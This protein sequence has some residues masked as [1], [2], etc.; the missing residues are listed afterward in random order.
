V[1]APWLAERLRL[2]VEQARQALLDHVR[3]CLDTCHLA[4]AFEDPV[5][6]LERYTGLGIQ[7][8]KLQIS[9]GPRVLLPEDRTARAALVA[10]L[11]PFADSPYLHQVGQRNR[12][13]SLQSYPDLVDALERIHDPEIAEWRI[14]FHAPIFIERY[15]SF[16]ST[17][18][19][20]RRTLE[21]VRQRGCCD[22]FEIETYTWDVL[23]P[24]YKRDLVDSVVREFAWVLDVLR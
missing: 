15:A 16:D 10:A 4:V 5:A 14:H 21:L 1:G 20:L 3:V 6:V 23:P 24:A 13:G 8:G 2:G 19:G 17:Q 11:R 9:A 7:V 22:L 12:D 18:D